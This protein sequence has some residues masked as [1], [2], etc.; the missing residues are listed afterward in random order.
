MKL[1]LQMGHGMQ[2]IC[3]DLSQAWGGATVI[4][5]PRNLTPSQVTSFANKMQKVNGSVLFDPQLYTPRKHHKKLNKHDYWPQS[6]FTSIELGDCSDLLKKLAST[7]SK[8]GAESFI[9][10]SSLINKIDYRWGAIQSSLADQAKQVEGTLPLLLT[11]ALGKDVLLDDVQVENIIQYAEQWD[12]EGI[13]LVCEHPDPKYLVE[14]PIWVANLL[15]LVAGLKRIGKKVVVGYANH[16]MLPLALTQC[17]AIAAGNYLNVRWFQPGNFETTDE[18]DPSRQATWFYS[19]Q[20]LSEFKITFLDVAHR[21]GLLAAL[22]PPPQME[23]VYS[24]ILF[25]GATPTTTNYRQ[26][27]SFKHYLHCLRIQAQTATKA[28][29]I[30]TRDAQFAQLETAARILTALHNQRIRGQDR[31]F[32]EICEVNEAAIQLFDN[33]FGFA[34]AQEWK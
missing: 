5:S 16:Q 7:N 23:N 30:E 31:D 26:G 34:M 19:P 27:D 28:S 18:D 22:Q 32:G 17:D 20:A 2:G 15:S 10:P 25:E 29:Y 21:S 4:M 6:D 9:I 14:K 8:I 24:R 12:V 33:E 11:V 3:E 13:Y 1:Y